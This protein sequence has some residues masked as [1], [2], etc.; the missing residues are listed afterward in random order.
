MDVRVGLQRKLSAKELM[1]LNYGVE[2]TLES[3]LD[4]KEIQ[5]VHPKGNQSWIFIGRMKLNLQN[6]GHL[7]WSTD[8]FEKTLLLGKIEGGRRRGWL[9]MR[10]L[11]GITDSIITVPIAQTVK[12]MPTMKETQIR[13]LGQ[14]IPWRRKWQPTPVLLPGKCHRLRSLVG[15]CPWGS[16]EYD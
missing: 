11:D 15:Y 16:K 3:P 4:C 7:M 12:L 6:S 13:S 2:K 8:S 9:R 5:S 14:E 10:Y 1:L